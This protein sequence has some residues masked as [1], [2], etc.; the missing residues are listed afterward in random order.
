MKNESFEKFLAQLSARNSGHQPEYLQACTE[1]V[2]SIWPFV[3]KNP[4][5]QEQGL[6]ERLLMPERIIIFRVVWADDKGEVHINKGYRIQHSSSLG[7]YKGGMRFHPTVNLSIM[8]FLALEQTLKNALT[9]LPMGGGKGGSDF[10]PKGKST[11]EIM[12]FC[13]AFM[14]EMYRHLGA[15][16]DVPAGDIGVSGREIGFMA[17]MMKKLSNKA[18][19]V[20]TGKGI[21]HGGSLIRPESTGYGL[22]YFTQ[23]MLKNK[24][25][26]L[27]GLRVGV[28]GSGNVAQYAIEK[29]LALGAKVVTA[30]DSAGTVYDPEGFTQEKL[31]ILMDIKNKQ[32]ER[33][34]KYAKQ[35]G[36]QY[37][38]NVKPWQFKVDVALPCAT[39][40]ELDDKDADMLIKHGTI[41]VAEGANMPTTISATKKLEQSGVLFA[42]GKASNAGGVSTSGFEMSQNAIRLFWTREEVEAKLHKTMCD[43]HESCLLHG[44]NPDGTFSYQTGANVSSFT[45]V[46]NAMIAQGLI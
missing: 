30:S 34:S 36:A 16:T 15:D 32:Y 18:D 9:T 45:R 22:V 20:F 27:E 21:S 6:L 19:C 3:E 38:E 8:K 40:N 33:I 28:S 44:Y 23:E 2:E 35:V 37:H 26:D 43:I 7:P 31:A 29:A 10:D 5:Y 46:A 4:Q 12:R 24:G 42:P 41:C 13:Q 25:Q 39:Q 17:G 11:A 14:S 1:I